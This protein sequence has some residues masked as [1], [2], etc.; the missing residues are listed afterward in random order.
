MNCKRQCRDGC[1][2]NLFRR[3]ENQRGF[4]KLQ[5]RVTWIQSVF[6]AIP[7]IAK[8]IYSPLAVGKKFGV[9][10]LCVETRHRSAI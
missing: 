1:L 10:L 2:L 3:L 8:K 7:E 6:I 4:R 5:A 9:E